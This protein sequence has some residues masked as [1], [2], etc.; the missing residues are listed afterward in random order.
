M[1]LAALDQVGYRPCV[2]YDG[3]PWE[4]AFGGLSE[5]G[6]DFSDEDYL[7]VPPV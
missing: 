1:D 5:S 2:V 6:V 4:M 3:G 7:R